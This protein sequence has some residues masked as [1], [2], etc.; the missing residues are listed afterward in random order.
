ML[1]KTFIGCLFQASLCLAALSTQVWGIDVYRGVNASVAGRANLG[2]AQFGFTGTPPT[3]STWATFPLVAINNN[4]AIRPCYYRFNINNVPHNPPQTNDLG[5][6]AGPTYHG[7]MNFSALFDNTPP[8]HWSIL[9]PEGV[10][11]DEAAINEAKA[12]IS[13]WAQANRGVNVER[14]T[15]ANCN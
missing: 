7:N 9:L 1:K 13:A 12:E 4:S 14:G 5:T 11:I 15:N 2:P 3:L 6:L 10:T 8:G